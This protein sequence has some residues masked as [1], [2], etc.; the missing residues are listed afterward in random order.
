MRLFLVASAAPTRTM[1][2]WSKTWRVSTLPCPWH[3][4]T[5]WHCRRTLRSLAFVPSKDPE[6]RVE[7]D[8]ALNLPTLLAT[9]FR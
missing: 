5:P 2:G 6:P 3:P 8:L 4:R 9:A 7:P 1:I